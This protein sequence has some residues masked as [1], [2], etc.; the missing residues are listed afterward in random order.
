MPSLK[1]NTYNI[2]NIIIPAVDET[3][4]VVMSAKNAM[5]GVNCAT[6]A[7]N[8]ASINESLDSIIAKT[9][10]IITWLEG[11]VRDFEAKENN[12]EEMASVLPTVELE[13]RANNIEIRNILP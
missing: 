5:A 7:G 3:K 6:F 12:F 8:T 9:T 13:P 2:T 4:K 10:K 11:S 1:I